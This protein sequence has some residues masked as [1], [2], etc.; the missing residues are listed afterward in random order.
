MAYD[1]LEKRRFNLQM[2]KFEIVYYAYR[3]W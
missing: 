2:M 1:V 3:N